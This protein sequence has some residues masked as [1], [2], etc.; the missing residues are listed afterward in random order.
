[1]LNPGGCNQVDGL[2]LGR[3]ILAVHGN[4]TFD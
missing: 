4:E 1:M 2:L 3:T